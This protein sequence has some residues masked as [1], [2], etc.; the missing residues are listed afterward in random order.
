[1]KAVVE[2]EAAVIAKGLTVAQRRQIDRNAIGG[3]FA[4]STVRVLI[5]KG[6]FEVRPD[7]PNGRW[8]PCAIT[9]LGLAVREHLTATPPHPDTTPGAEG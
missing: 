1:M 4:M 8:G 5:R 6:L 2:G 3:D 7:S 9:E